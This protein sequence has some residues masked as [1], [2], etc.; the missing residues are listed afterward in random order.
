MGLNRHQAG[1]SC[2][3]LSASTTRATAVGLLHPVRLRQLQASGGL[4]AGCFAAVA[5]HLLLEG[6][7]V[8]QGP[9]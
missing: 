8:S 6:I 2:G 3:D 7:A 4:V 5:K 9:F 1:S